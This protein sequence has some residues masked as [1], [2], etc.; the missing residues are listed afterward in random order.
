MPD[1]TV[2]FPD[3]SVDVSVDPSSASVKPADTA[4]SKF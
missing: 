1:T 4:K 2:T 3:G